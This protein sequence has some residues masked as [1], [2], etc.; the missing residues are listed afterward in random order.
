MDKSNPVCCP[1]IPG[2]NLQKDENGEKIDITYY[3]QIIGSL[4]YLT[5]TRSDVGFVVSLISRY[6]EHP[7]KIHLQAGGNKEHIAYTNNDYAGELNDRKNTSG[8]IFL[9]SSGAVSWLSNKQP[10]V[11][12]STKEAEFIAAAVCAC[13]AV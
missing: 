9:L 5:A 12:L 4:M 11:S 7:T 10:M 3:K 13:Q 1:I 2:E 8:Y 6:M